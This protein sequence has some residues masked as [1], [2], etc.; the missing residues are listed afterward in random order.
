MATFV[1]EPP[2]TAGGPFIHDVNIYLKT[3]YGRVLKR[4]RL[5]EGSGKRKLR[6]NNNKIATHD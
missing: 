1:E 6:S 3:V 5:R 2:A 4:G